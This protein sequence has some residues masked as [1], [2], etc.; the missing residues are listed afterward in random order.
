MT[1]KQQDGLRAPS[2]LRWV[3]IRLSISVAVLMLVA[4]GVQIL[5]SII[6]TDY[7]WVSIGWSILIVAPFA[8]GAI[9]ELIAR[10]PGRPGGG[11]PGVGPL[12]VLIVLIA[13]AIFLR[14]G[15]ICVVILAPLWLSSAVVGSFAAAHFRDAFD[16]RYRSNILLLAAAPFLA[17]FLDANVP[18]P[19][20]HFSVSRSIVID[21]REAEIWPHLLQLDG[22]TADEGVWNITQDVLGVP[23][24]SSA[25]VVGEGVGSVRQARWGA[26]IRFEEHI[27]D[28]RQNERLA[29]DFAFPDDS[30]SRYTDPH[31]HPDGA[32]LK[33]AHGAYRLDPLPGGK[34]RL[35]LETR[36]IARSPVN[37]YAALWG[38][39]F[40]GDIQTN[41]LAVVK[42]RAEG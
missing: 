15:M 30:I 17:L 33:V 24:P 9:A 4:L 35:T 11:I 23:R 6:A 19:V 21:A 29:W 40:L 13:G 38:E 1:V 12:A 10:P 25:V 8:L 5:G 22:L 2:A 27:T 14:E 18:P 34:A 31:I 32:N 26:N 37:P 41:I 42:A 36:Y 28:W 7:A 3:V 20:D 39:L 16:K